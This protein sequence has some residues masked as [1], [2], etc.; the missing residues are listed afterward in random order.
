[1]SFGDL[2]RATTLSPDGSGWIT[3]EPHSGADT[4][5]TD[6]VIAAAPHRH[7]P[8]GVDEPYIEV[9]LG[10]RLLSIPLAAVV[11]YRPDP[12]PRRRWEEAFAPPRK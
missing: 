1:M 6:G 8:V 2:V 10:A 3:W 7:F 4:V 12:E 11:S 9:S 5:R